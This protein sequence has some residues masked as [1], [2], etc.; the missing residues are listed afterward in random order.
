MSELRP[1][2]WQRTKNV[3]LRLS[4]PV[5][6]RRRGLPPDA[7]CPQIAGITEDGMEINRP[8]RTGQDAVVF[9]EKTPR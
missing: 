2:K 4:W 7:A 3:W 6:R 1:V 9:A 8:R 5:V